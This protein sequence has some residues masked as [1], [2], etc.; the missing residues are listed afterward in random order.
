V[1]RF[2]GRFRPG[3]SL[4]A[5]FLGLLRGGRHIRQLII[6]PLFAGFPVGVYLRPKF[7]AGI[8]LLPGK[9]SLLGGKEA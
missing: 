3:G 6:G 8:D 9:M 1:F 5:L 2:P 7:T 4:G